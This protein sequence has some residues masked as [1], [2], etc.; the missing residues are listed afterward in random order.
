MLFR[1]LLLVLVCFA[2]CIVF[3]ARRDTEPSVLVRTAAVR[4]L[5]VSL[6]VGIAYVG[7]T[8]VTSWFIDA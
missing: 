6:Y 4:G 2:G 8:L 7:M 1:I 3:Y 5:I